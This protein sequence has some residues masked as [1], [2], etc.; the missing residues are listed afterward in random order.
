MTLTFSLGSRG[1]SS[2]R[3]VAGKAES[4]LTFN[5]SLF[6]RY[7]NQMGISRALDWKWRCVTFSFDL[8]YR[9][10]LPTLRFI[11]L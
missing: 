11:Y 3:C 6:R 5:R 4:L 8:R 7:R 1:L 10:I 9:I 2:G